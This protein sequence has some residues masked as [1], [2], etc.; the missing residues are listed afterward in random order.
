MGKPGRGPEAVATAEFPAD[1]H[2]LSDSIKSVLPGSAPCD[3]T[4]SCLD[5]N[6]EEDQQYY[7]DAYFAAG[8]NKSD[9]QDNNEGHGKEPSKEEVEAFARHLRP[10]ILGVLSLL[11]LY[12]VYRGAMMLRLRK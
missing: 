9:E 4:F 3:F 5:D 7:F 12:S 6:T 10:F 1:D 8:N 2:R 11:V